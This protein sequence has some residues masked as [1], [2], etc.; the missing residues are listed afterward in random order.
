MP[1][2]SFSCPHC[3]QVLEAPEEMAGEVVDC[4][5]CE[6]SMTVPTVPRTTGT[7]PDEGRCPACGAE[8]EPNAVLCVG[9]GYHKELG[10][11]IT[12]SF[13]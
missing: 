6:Q 4:P 7:S 11:K 2:V 3:Q 10:R 1:D 13:E 9:C 5:A 12:T 8:M